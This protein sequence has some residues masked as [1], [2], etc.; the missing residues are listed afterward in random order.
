[1]LNTKDHSL[2]KYIFTFFLV[3]I[4]PVSCKKI[5]DLQNNPNEATTAPPSVIFTGILQNMFAY[6]WNNSQSSSQY[7]CETANY[8]GEQSYQFGAATYY[9]YSLRNV[10]QM[11]READR[12]QDDALRPYYAI[13]NFL[14]AFFY[15]NMTEQVGDIPMSQAMMAEAGIYQPV[16]D[17]QKSIYIQCFKWLD[18]AN[19]SLA[20]LSENKAYTIGGDIFFAGNLVKWRKL[21]N[22]FRLRVL[23]S[24]SRKEGDPDLQIRKQFAEIL[25]HPDEYP[26]ITA[27]E[28][29]M[30]ITYDANTVDN[31][32]PAFSENPLAEAKRKPLGATYVNLLK[33]LKDPRLLKNALP[34]AR[35]VPG[36]T[37]LNKTLYDAYRG[38]PT[39]ALQVELSDSVNA[40]YYSLANYDYWFTSKT[41]VPTI[42]V[43][44]SEVD[45]S[46]AEGIN[47]GWADNND[48]GLAGYYYKKGI[49]ES[50][51]FYTVDPSMIK[52]YLQQPSVQYKG[53]NSK[54]LEQILIQKYIAFFQ[55]SG[56]ESFYNYRRTGIPVFSIGPSNKNNGLIPKRWFYP[57][58]DY[59]DNLVNLKAAL[60]RQYGGADDL[61]DL[62]WI[63]K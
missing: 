36:D 57:Q 29:N 34:A 20:T 22:S 35:S 49:M 23:I 26:I 30:Q 19:D 12:I 47:R 51:R 3:L 18:L 42:L 62:M 59:F 2:F 61:N 11:I 40:G 17:S 48:P 14:K 25:G 46:L 55:N 13:S 43:G 16:Y 21:I 4:F 39:G 1:M 7:Y 56:W 58:S 60:Q 41:G 32:N 28:D 15:I 53:N 27:N 33:G 52:T 38:A 54:G 50:M 10:N 44:A 6:P 24:L 8:Y 31:Y 37:A 63:L 45:F 5:S 9:Y